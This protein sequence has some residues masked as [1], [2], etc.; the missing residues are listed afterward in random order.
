VFGWELRWAD[1]H[2]DLLAVRPG[3]DLAIGACGPL[4]TDGTLA[5][6]ARRGGRPHQAF[7]HAGY[8]LAVGRRVLLDEH[9]GGTW[10]WPGR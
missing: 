5:F 6:V 4:E 10:E 3:L 8:R 9:R 7:L 1:G 2:S